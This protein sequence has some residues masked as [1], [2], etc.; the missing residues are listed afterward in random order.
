MGGG[1]AH[2]LAA[3]QCRRDGVRL[4]AGPISARVTRRVR[5]RRGGSTEWLRVAVEVWRAPTRVGLF[6]GQSYEIQRLRSGHHGMFCECVL[7]SGPA[8]DR[9]SNL[10]YSRKAWRFVS[11]FRACTSTDG[12]VHTQWSVIR[13]TATSII[14]K[15]DAVTTTG[16][17]TSS[18]TSVEGDEARCICRLH[19][20]RRAH[21]PY[22]IHRPTVRITQFSPVRLTRGDH[23]RPGGS[24]VSTI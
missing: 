10:P 23:R 20:S 16:L 11:C 9:L 18:S 15:N 21:G 19:E 3:W 24:G 12:T 4:L 2:E 6:T 5:G 7:G 13:R 22:T 1:A 14:V 17:R 8:E